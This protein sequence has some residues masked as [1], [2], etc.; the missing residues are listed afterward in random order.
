MT[1]SSSRFAA[2][3]N[4]PIFQI[5][6]SSAASTDDASELEAIAN[7]TNPKK[8]LRIASLHLPGLIAW[9][10]PLHILLLGGG[11]GL[12]ALGARADD[13]DLIAIGKAVRR[14]NDDAVIG[15]KA[16]GEFDLLAEVAGNGDFLEQHLVV[17]ADGCDRQAA[18]IE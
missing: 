12:A 5:F 17:A 4:I 6:L 16:R 1:A 10:L 8:R 18:A 3:H 13:A 2:C 14:G 11:G 15:R 7:A 9:P